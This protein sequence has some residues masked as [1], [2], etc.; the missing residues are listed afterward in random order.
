MTTEIAS[1]RLTPAQGEALRHD[2]ATDPTMTIARLRAKYGVSQ[3]EVYRWLNGGPRVSGARMFPP[4]ERRSPIRQRQTEREKLVMRLWRAAS[5]EVRTL[6]A[7]MKAAPEPDEGRA[8]AMAALVKTL[9]DLH[10]LDG[11]KPARKRTR[12]AESSPEPNDDDSRKSDQGTGN[13][14]DDPREIDAFRRELARRI[15]ALDAGS[16]DDAAGGA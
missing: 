15:A 11:G 3:Y 9:R 4:V 13:I 8:R 7:R 10:E 12:G 5:V 14:A 1:A 6:E 16:A 2:Y